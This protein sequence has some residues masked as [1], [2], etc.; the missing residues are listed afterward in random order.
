MSLTDF[1]NSCLEIQSYCRSS[2]NEKCGI[3][4]NIKT[5]IVKNC[6][7]DK[8]TF[9]YI[10]P[11]EYYNIYCKEIVQFIWH[12]HPVGDASPSHIDIDASNEHQYNSIIFSKENKNFSLYRFDLPSVVYFSV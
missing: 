9:F 12:C 8:K 2:D 5:H 4:T 10:D 11:R 7:Q 6:S 3:T 1:V